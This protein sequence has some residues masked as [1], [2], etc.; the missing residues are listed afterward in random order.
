MLADQHRSMLGDSVT[1]KIADSVAAA[2][3]M[4]D[5]GLSVATEKIV[6]TQRPL[7]GQIEEHK[8]ET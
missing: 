5:S 7:A 3:R 4:A 6:S 8:Q 1:M 2:V